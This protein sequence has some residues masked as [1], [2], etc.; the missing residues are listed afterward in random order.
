MLHRRAGI[1]FVVVAALLLGGA[2]VAVMAVRSVFHSSATEVTPVTQASNPGL[3][4]APETGAIAPAFAVPAYDERSTVHLDAFRGHPVVLN[5]WASWC[6]PCRAETAILQAA[7][8]RYKDRGV[9]FIGIDSQTDT[10]KGSREF[11]T[12]HGVT[13]PVGRDERGSVARAYRVTGLPTTYFIGADGR[14]QGV[15]V[16]G[17]FTDADGARDLASA[18]EKMLH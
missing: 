7:Y 13:Y 3:R 1:S 6:P 15:G 18:V 11:L 12:Q 17:G 10:W 9:V 14:V 8:L 5:F 4:T 16:E 2:G